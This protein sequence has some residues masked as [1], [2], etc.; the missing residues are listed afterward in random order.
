MSLL[1]L[2]YTNPIEFFIISL[3]LILTI[4]L[5]EFAHAFVAD[6]LGDPTPRIEGRVTLNPIAHLDPLGTL[7][8]FVIG[9]GWGKP[10][11]FDP[12][13]LRNP[14]R[15]SALISL[16]GPLSNFIMAIMASVA[17]RFI[18]QG[19]LIQDMLVY[20]IY[21]SLFLGLF[22]FL[23]FHPL[24]GF[25]IVLGILPK[26]MALEWAGLERYGMIILLFLILP[27]GGR[28]FIGS[29][30]SPIVQALFVFLTQF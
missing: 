13:N 16:A 14:L 12:F 30:L 6:R 28:S 17:L 26:K 23:P 1:Q 4:A 21:Y 27:I 7:L 24:D 8:I 18:P 25:K 10:V 29:V 22:N 15:D 2:L 5:H 3:A 9:F 11:R 19:A 20:F